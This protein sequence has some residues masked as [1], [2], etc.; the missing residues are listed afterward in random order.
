MDRTLNMDGKVYYISKTQIYEEFKDLVDF[1]HA[2]PQKELIFGETIDDIIYDNTF[3]D[4]RK[5]VEEGIINKN[6]IK[7]HRIYRLINTNRRFYKR[8]LEG[9]YEI[10]DDVYLMIRLQNT[11]NC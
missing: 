8:F 4:L 1:N 5:L 6:K 9:V 11:I 7:R 2:Y 10:P 3:T